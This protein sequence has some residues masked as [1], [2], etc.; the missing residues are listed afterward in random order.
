MAGDGV[1]DRG[2]RLMVQ[3]GS[4]WGGVR[5]GGDRPRERV[6]KSLLSLER[7]EGPS[8][9]H[10]RTSIP[11]RGNSTD[12]GPEAERRGLERLRMKL[13]APEE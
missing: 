7:N 5:G 13:G 4:G 11:G 3:D 12:D 6:S 10:A 9:V 8:Q 1:V 2:L